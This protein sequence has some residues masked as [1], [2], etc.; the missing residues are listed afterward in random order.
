MALLDTQ[1]ILKETERLMAVE[2]REMLQYACY[3]LGNIDDAEDVVQDVFI[4]L[5]QRLSD[6]RIYL[7]GQHPSVGT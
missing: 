4:L 7:V 5:H 3:R 6:D 2:R 1:S